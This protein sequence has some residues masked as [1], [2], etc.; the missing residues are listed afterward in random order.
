MSTSVSGPKRP[1]DR[2]EIGDLKNRF[3]SLLEAPMN[4]G[5]FGLS[6]SELEARCDFRIRG[7]AYEPHTIS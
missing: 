6:G 4:E 2:I 1:Q 3:L 7:R 5:G